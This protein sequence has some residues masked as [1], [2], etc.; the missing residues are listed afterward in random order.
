VNIKDRFKPI[1]QPLINSTYFFLVNTLGKEHIAMK[2]QVLSCLKKLVKIDG[3]NS[4][5]VVYYLSRVWGPNAV[6]DMLFELCTEVEEDDQTLL[7][8]CIADI[9]QHCNDWKKHAN[10]IREMLESMGMTVSYST[11]KGVVLQKN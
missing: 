9:I 4:V 1:L 3:P 11:S 10:K 2:Q 8:S 5:L 6:I 7:F